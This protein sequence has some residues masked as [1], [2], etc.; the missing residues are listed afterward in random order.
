MSRLPRKCFETNYFH[1]IV[2]GIGK[3]KIFETGRL[4]SEYLNDIEMF[5]QAHGIKI[6]TYCVMDNH[7]HILLYAPDTNALGA[8]MLRVN[9][10]YAQYYNKTNDRVG[11]VFRDRYRS[12]PIFKDEY[13]L[14]CMVYIHNN[15]VKVRVSQTAADYSYSGLQCYY[16][17][18]GVVD[19]DEAA[20]FLDVSSDN[21]EAVMKEKFDSADEGCPI[22]DDI[23]EEQKS[24]AEIAAD[25]TADFGDVRLLRYDK[26]R[27]TKLA[28][29]MKAAGVGRAE[30]AA[31]IG[32]P[33][34]T[35]YDLTKPRDLKT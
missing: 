33:V 14:N 16:S 25:I 24:S 20:K 19:F 9:T 10:R 27:L 3:E 22:W 5:K 1:V 30:M 34:R 2:Q 23:K 28:E 12:Q 18:N 4:K 13:L 15:P 31:A 6:L 21:L 7:C 29:K 35:L 17:R 11:Y 26:E 8:F 32:V